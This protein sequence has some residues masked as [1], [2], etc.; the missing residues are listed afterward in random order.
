MRVRQGSQFGVIAATALAVA[1]TAGVIGAV[2]SATKDDH[3]HTVVMEVGY[4]R[5]DGVDAGSDRVKL[6]QGKVDS[7]V[8]ELTPRADER[9]AD[10]RRWKKW[11]HTWTGPNEPR[12]AEA[13]IVTSDSAGQVFCMLTVD[14]KVVDGGPEKSHLQLITCSYPLPSYGH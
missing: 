4:R 11:R 1:A 14:G 12:S 6:T 3:Q 8:Y 2:N 9:Y 7:A 13:T 10:G 5:Q